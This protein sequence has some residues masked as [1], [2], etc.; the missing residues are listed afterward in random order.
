M[1]FFG[2]GNVVAYAIGDDNSPRGGEGIGLG[3]INTCL[4]GGGAGFGPAIGALLIW[5][6]PHATHSADYTMT[7]LNIAF[8]PVTVCLV[9]ACVTSLIV[10][11]TH[12]ARTAP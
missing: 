3:F 5:Q 6:Q 12:C 8:L 11:E 4:I 9:I 1:G 2:C 7:E 10:R